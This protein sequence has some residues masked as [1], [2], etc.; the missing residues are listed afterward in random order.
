MS[1]L[2]FLSA[3][4]CPKLGDVRLRIVLHTRTHTHTHTHTHINSSSFIS[5]IQ[6]RIFGYCFIQIV[7]VT[8]IV[9]G[10]SVMKYSFAFG[11]LRKLKVHSC[12]PQ[13]QIYYLVSEFLINPRIFSAMLECFR[14]EEREE[15]W[16]QLN[17]LV[18][19]FK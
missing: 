12:E 19:F 4:V 3:Q 1:A 17:V 9:V 7:N 18:G 5:L 2:G 13:E 11:K 6:I 15:L 16:R 8:F 10:S 14:E